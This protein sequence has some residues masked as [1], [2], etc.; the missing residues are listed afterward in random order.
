MPEWD[1]GKSRQAISPC[2]PQARGLPCAPAHFSAGA[3]HPQPPPSVFPPLFLFHPVPPPKDLQ[4]PLHRKYN[5]TCALISIASP[6]PFSHSRLPHRY[7]LSSHAF[8]PPAVSLMRPPALYTL[9][10]T[11]FPPSKA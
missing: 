3:G 9:Y 7:R 4:N 2:I 6:V 5:G 11:D 10:P 8:L 1:C